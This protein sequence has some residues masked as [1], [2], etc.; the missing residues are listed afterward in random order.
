MRGVFLDRDGVINALVYHPEAGVI[1]S[2]STPAQFRLLPRVPQAIRRLNDLG[3]RVVVV[4]NQPG[5]AK[6][7]FGTKTLKTFERK[8]LA[9]IAAAGARIDWIYYCLHHPEAKVKALRKNCHCRKPKI[10]MLE[11]AALELDLPLRQFYMIGDGLP[12][13]MA[14]AR[15]GCRT[16]FVGRWKCEICQYMEPPGLRPDLVVKNLWEASHVIEQEMRSGSWIPAA[17]GGKRCS[18]LAMDRSR[19]GP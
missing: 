15:A 14:G 16:I 10:G 1:D 17:A 3:L 4:S 5:I 6:G 7:R 13:M 18:G 2:P 9:G 19:S 8:M 11:R 12:D